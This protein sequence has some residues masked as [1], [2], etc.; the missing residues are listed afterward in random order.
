MFFKSKFELSTFVAVVVTSIVLKALAVS[1]LSITPVSDAIAYWNMAT[2]LMETG[3]MDDGHGNLA[4]YS[5]GYPLFLIPFI[6]LFGKTYEVAQF[7]N[8]FLGAVSTILLYFCAKT[9]LKS[10]FWALIS[11]LAWI[12]YPPNILYTEYLA[13]E[14]LMTPLLLGQTLLLLNY[15]GEKIKTFL[16]G[17]IFALG[18]LVGSAILFTI[19]PIIFFLINFNKEKSRISLSSIS[20][21]LVFFIVFFITL[22]PWLIYTKS[23]LGEPVLT[24]NGGFNLYLGN[25]KNSTA[26]YMS[27]MDT[28]IADEWYELKREKGELKAFNHLKQLALTHIFENPVSTIKLS[29]EKVI[30]FWTPPYHEG[31]GEKSSGES[32]IRLVW[33]VIYSTIISLALGSLFF[34]RKFNR[35]HYLILSTIL[36]YCLIHGAI[37]VI[38]RYRLPI[39]P[40]VI[41]LSTFTSKEIFYNVFRKR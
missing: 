32:L 19:I 9:F 7:V 23:H 4:F 37:Y 12:F 14:N 39:I 2:S 17:L 11:C 27:I 21:V 6:S 10:H 34:I 33:L 29:I 26:Y 20:N 31:K 25:N 24:T 36:L 35:K 38:Y 15:Q 13:K 3:V 28:P 40:L 41:I 16:L 5:A 18:V 8:V 1:F 30:V 22:F